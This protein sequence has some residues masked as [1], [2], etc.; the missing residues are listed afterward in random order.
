MVLPQD[1]KHCLMRRRYH[2]KKRQNE[3]AKDICSICRENFESGELVARFDG[4]RHVGTHASC[5]AESMAHGHLGA[6]FNFASYSHFKAYSELIINQNVDFFR[7]RKDFD[8]TVG[9][10][11]VDLLLPD[12]SLSADKSVPTTPVERRVALKETLVNVDQVC[13]IFV[14]KGLVALIDMAPPSTEQI[15]DW[16]NDLSVLSWSIALDGDVTLG[17]QILL[18]EQGLL[19]PSFVRYALQTILQSVGGQQVSIEDYYMDTDYNSDPEKF[20]VKE[21]LLNIIME[22]E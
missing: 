20:E 13:R 7:F 2:E 22:S 12:R 10:A 14:E 1:K 16:A 15:D 18:Q 4:C 17:S 11:L 5:L 21:V 9:R 19:Y 6:E 8:R 3:T